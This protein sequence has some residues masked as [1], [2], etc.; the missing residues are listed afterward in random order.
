[1]KRSNHKIV[2]AYEQETAE[3][4]VIPV[5]TSVATLMQNTN[6]NR[7]L[8]YSGDIVDMTYTSLQERRAMLR[9]INLQV[10]KDRENVITERDNIA[11]AD[12]FRKQMENN[13]KTAE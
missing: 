10:E 4:F 7:E 11:Y 5:D 13:S 2:T 3:A 8:N 12:Q 1:M 6:P 9:D